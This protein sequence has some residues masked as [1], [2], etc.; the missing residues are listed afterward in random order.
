[1]KREKL[2][3]ERNAMLNKQPIANEYDLEHRAR[4]LYASDI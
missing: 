4:M 2:F 1:M 3:S